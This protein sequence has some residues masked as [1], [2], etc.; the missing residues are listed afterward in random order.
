MKR[1]GYI[2]VLVL[3]SVTLRL[4]A[5]IDPSSIARVEDGKVIYQ[6]DLNWSDTQKK[7]VIQLFDLDS[8]V[9]MKVATGKS[10]ILL[11]SAQWYVRKISRDKVELSKPLER[12]PAAHINKFDI[13]LGNDNLKTPPGYV[14]QEKIVYGFNSFS[15]NNVYRYNK[16]IVQFFLP[17]NTKV[18]KVFIAGSFNDW[19]PRKTA[20]QRVDSGWIV[21]IALKPGKYFYKYILDG[22]WITDPNNRFD[23]N[24]GMGNINSVLYLPNFEFKL[25]NYKEAKKVVV[26][27]SFNNYNPTE[28]RMRRTSNG[29]TLPL[30][31]KD[32]TYSYKFLVDDKWI[33]DPNNETTRKDLQGNKNSVVLKGDEHVFRLRGYETARQVMLAGNFNKWKPNELSMNKVAE[34]WE[35]PFRFSPGNYEY[36]FIVDGHWMHDPAN[37][38]VTGNGDLTNSILAYKPNHTFK[39]NGYANARHVVVTG[40]FLDWNPEGYKMVKKDGVWI[41]PIHLNKGKHLYKMIVDGKWI[42]DPGNKLWE[43][44]E[45]GTGNSVLWIE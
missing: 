29:W 30:Y 45:F 14:D 5:Q 15:R 2:L 44:N 23:E 26:G 13:L 9:W 18:R 34:G 43:Q 31:L 21:K 7:Q 22:N 20:M 10:E 1:A 25:N 4:G 39:L 3:I 40:S 17:G 27:G 36:K 33:T 28:L 6:L 32:G 35:L 11:D 41:F 12:K 19:A 38:F 8:T 37:P 42:L 16:G 24:D